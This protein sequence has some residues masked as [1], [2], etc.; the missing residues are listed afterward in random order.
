MD[1]YVLIALLP[2]VLRELREWAPLL[3]DPVCA[4]AV[5]LA[6]ARRRRK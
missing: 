3:S 6:K 5:R 1:N 2:I 4:R